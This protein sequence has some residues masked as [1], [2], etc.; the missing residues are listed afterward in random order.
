MRQAAEAGPY[1]G[2]VRELA[3][4]A[5]AAIK[6]VEETDSTNADAAALIDDERFGGQTIVAEYQ[7]RGAGRKGRVWRAPAGTA[8]LFT[9]ILPRTIDTDKLWIVP[10]WAALA[11][12]AALLDFGVKPTLQWPN[13]LLLG[14]R[15][16]A[17]VLCQSSVSGPTARVAC[18][19]GINVHRPGAE[20][21]IEPPPAFCDD[22][23][24]AVERAALLRR[25]LL[26]YDRRLFMLNQPENVAAAWDDAAEL[27]GKRY[28]IQLDGEEQPFEAIAQGL[29]SGGG[30][31]VTRRDG[32]AE[33]VSLGDARVV[34]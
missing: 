18:G 9:T 23:V 27:P 3:G 34:R 22:D 32:T 12:R 6:Y 19:V 7:R 21:G 5:F 16:V 26:E 4:T 20:A 8:L 2:A 17:G 11:V 31:R 33:I 13:D 28:R 10:Y 14:E 15:K 29:A 30:L 24:A 25:I 1:E